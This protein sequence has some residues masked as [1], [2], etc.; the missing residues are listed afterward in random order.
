[1]NQSSTYQQYKPTIKFMV[2]FALTYITLTIIYGLYLNR[3][4]GHTDGL[5]K[6]VGKMVS[7]SYNLLGID[8]QTIPLE[9]ESGLKLIIQGNYVARIVEGCT[10]MS[11][12]IMFVAFILSFGKHIKTSITYA[13][14]G[15]ILIFVFNI[16]RIVFL[17]YLLYTAP[18]YQDVS[19]RV[20]FP[21]MIYGFVI[22]LWILFIKKYNK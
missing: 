12:I 19:H 5:T 6:F 2:I 9:N 20:I 17:G 13:L 3:F 21:V 18:Q 11:V 14:I 10:A 1:M 22:L 4:N 15:S 8:A 7:H 16:I